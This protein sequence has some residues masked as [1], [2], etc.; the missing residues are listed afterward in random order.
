[1][2]SDIVLL[3]LIAKTLKIYLNIL[4]DKLS[5]TLLAIRH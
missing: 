2:I 4:Q 1:M 3:I 5:N